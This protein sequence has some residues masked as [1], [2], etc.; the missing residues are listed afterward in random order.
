M[1]FTENTTPAISDSWLLGTF[2]RFLLGSWGWLRSLPSAD[3]NN[4]RVYILGTTSP[5]S[6]LCMV[7]ISILQ[8]S[9]SS[10]WVMLFWIL[11][12]VILVPSSGWFIAGNLFSNLLI[13][14]APA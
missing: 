3:D 12:S 13:H 14:Q 5:V 11:N 10:F 7:R 2:C 1:A 4:L 6:I 9:A 8:R